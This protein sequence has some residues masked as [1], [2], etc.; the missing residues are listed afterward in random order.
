MLAVPMFG[1]TF[2]EITVPGSQ[3]TAANNINN[4]FQVVGFFADSSGTHG[5]LLSQG[6]YKT[7]NYPT[8]PNFTVA[9][10]IND[11][12]EVVGYFFNT[13]EHGFIDRGGTF[14]QF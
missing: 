2:H 5:F 9:T 10:G 3:S 1:A 7:L 14:T 8:V 11:A 13:A 4:R 12:D 6:T